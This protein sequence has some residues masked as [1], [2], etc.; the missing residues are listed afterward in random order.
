MIRYYQVGNIENESHFPQLPSVL[1]CMYSS[2]Q[3]KGIQHTTATQS[4]GYWCHLL[5]GCVSRLWAVPKRGR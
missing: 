4:I 2:I 1:N 3:S 5:V